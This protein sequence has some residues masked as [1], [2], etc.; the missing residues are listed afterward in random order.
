MLGRDLRQGQDG[1]ASETRCAGCFVWSVP[2]AV[3]TAVSPSTVPG[4][5]PTPDSRQL[6]ARSGSVPGLVKSHPSRTR[7]PVQRL[8][9]GVCGFP[10][11]PLCATSSFV[12]LDPSVAR[13]D[14]VFL[15]PSETAAPCPGSSAPCRGSLS[16]AGLGMAPGRKLGRGAFPPGASSLSRGWSLWTVSEWTVRGSALCSVKAFM[17]PGAL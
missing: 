12:L 4:T 7:L 15:P 16:C 6:A 2:P 14:P 13:H 8:R 1:S 17:V 3:W 9:E 10:G 5:V 11:L